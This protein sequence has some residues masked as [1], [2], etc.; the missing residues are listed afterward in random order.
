M[1]AYKHVLFCQKCIALELYFNKVCQE[2]K[3]NIVM[4]VCQA[5]VNIDAYTWM[6]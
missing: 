2:K 3:C 1:F 5:L 4:T 6:M